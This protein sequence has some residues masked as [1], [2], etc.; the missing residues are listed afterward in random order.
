M[1]FAFLQDA[2]GNFREIAPITIFSISTYFRRCKSGAGSREGKIKSLLH[3]WGQRGSPKAVVEPVAWPSGVVV[4]FCFVYGIFCFVLFL[5][6]SES[7][8]KRHSMGPL[9]KAL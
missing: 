3:P 6:A 9:R 5:K 1:G 2:A 4:W 7:D 8:T